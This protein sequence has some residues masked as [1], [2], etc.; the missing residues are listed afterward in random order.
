MT[1][2]R[3][4]IRTRLIRLTVAS[5]LVLGLGTVGAGPALAGGTWDGGT[6]SG[7]CAK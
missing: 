2:V 1:T 5:A 3:T 7:P 4:T 6:C